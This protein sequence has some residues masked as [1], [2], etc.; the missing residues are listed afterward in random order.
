MPEA[1]VSKPFHP[2]QVKALQE[3]RVPPLDLY[4]LREGDEAPVLFLSRSL[5]FDRRVSRNLAQSEIQ[6][7]FIREEDLEIFDEYLNRNIASIIRDPNISVH[8][9]CAI[10]YDLSLELMKRVYESADPVQVAKSSQGVLQNI[11]EVIFANPDAAHSFITL[12][13]EDYELYSHSINACLYGMALAR[14]ALDITKEEAL[15]R[16]GPGFLLH[17]IGKLSIPHD[18]LMKPGSL[19]EKEWDQVRLHPQKGLEMVEKIMPVTEETQAMILYHHERL[20]GSGYP[21]GLR[22]SE[23][24]IAARICGIV[25]AFDALSTNRPFQERKKTFEAFSVLKQ[26]E[27]PHRLDEN[28]FRDF[29]RVFHP[30]NIP[31]TMEM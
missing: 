23:I 31:M 27:V 1:A 18:I 5:P 21:L 26:E 13:S 12:T 9:R 2:I 4:I 6:I 28:F 19:T 7:L 22:G 15:T 25:D 16:F 8:S 17:D 14:L 30:D 29:V 3:G 20:D 11:I 10:T 24:P